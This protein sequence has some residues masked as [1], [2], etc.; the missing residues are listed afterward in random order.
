MDVSMFQHGPYTLPF[1]IGV[2]FTALDSP[3][4]PEVDSD[5][6]DSDEDDVSSSSYSSFKGQWNQD[7][8]GNYYRPQ[9]FI[10]IYPRVMVD[11]I[12]SVKFTI[13]VPSRLLPTQKNSRIYNVSVK[14]YELGDPDNV[15]EI[16]SARFMV[17]NR[18]PRPI[19][20]DGLGERMLES[21]D[22]A[23]RRLSDLA[24]QMNLRMMK[25][26]RRYGRS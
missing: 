2:H 7:G 26:M 19:E 4:A 12:C 14:A 18:I 22:R 17:L 13:H 15:T 21:N 16:S 8:P 9:S 25:R 23:Q 5:H 20:K 3:S 6:T 11:N 10:Q 24:S 1:S